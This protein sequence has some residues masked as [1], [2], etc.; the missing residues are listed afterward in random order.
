[1]RVARRFFEAQPARID[2][3]WCGPQGE[4]A[5]VVRRVHLWESNLANAKEFAQ[6][7]GADAASPW[8]ISVSE[9]VPILP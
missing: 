1:M 8:E 3:R 2:H 5:P 4:G 6:R 9:W 7:L